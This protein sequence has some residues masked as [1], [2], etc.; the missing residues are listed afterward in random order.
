M[1]A[2]NGS[3]QPGRQSGGGGGHRLTT[4]LL[5]DSYIQLCHDPLKDLHRWIDESRPGTSSETRPLYRETTDVIQRAS[6]ME[7]SRGLRGDAL[8][9]VQSRMDANR[10][11]RIDH[12]L[13]A[14]P[15]TG[16][17]SYDQLRSVS[18]EG[19]EGLNAAHDAG[20]HGLTAFASELGGV[21]SYYAARIA[22]ARLS[23]RPGDVAAAILA[24]LGEKTLATLAVLDRWMAAARAT[25]QKQ[26][27]KPPHPVARE[28]TAPLGV[29]RR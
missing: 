14:R 12:V 23:L 10:T 28:R 1:P 25:T 15:A 29:A 7:D 4:A 27:V 26:I 13:S 8:H 6:V 17:I 21:N 9:Q 20:D 11:A 2:Q 19:R 3:Q 22:A 5:A 18:V 16:S 24:I